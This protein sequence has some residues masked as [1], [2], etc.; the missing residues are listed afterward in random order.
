M[1]RRHDDRRWICAGFYIQCGTVG[2]E[3]AAG[4]G[5]GRIGEIKVSDEL[6]IT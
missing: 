1:E 5:F 6:S 4:R 3:R 2:E